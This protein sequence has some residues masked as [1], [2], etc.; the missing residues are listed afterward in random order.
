[1]INENEKQIINGKGKQKNVEQR[2]II[3]GNCGKSRLKRIS[4]PMLDVYHDKPRSMVNHCVCDCGA[5]L[6]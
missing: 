1:M 4:T 3:V 5:S 2:S 6:R